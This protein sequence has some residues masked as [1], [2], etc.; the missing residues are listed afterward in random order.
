MQSKRLSL[1]PIALS[2]VML[3]GCTWFAPKPL[4]PPAPCDCQQAIDDL[5]KQAELYH[6]ALKDKALLRESLKACERRGL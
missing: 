4:P 5:V 6:E 2:A 1:L 3:G